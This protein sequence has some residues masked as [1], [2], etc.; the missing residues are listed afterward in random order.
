MMQTKV[1]ISILHSSENIVHACFEV[2]LWIK[3]WYL[4]WHAEYVGWLIMSNDGELIRSPTSV[5]TY[6]AVR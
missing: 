4:Y 2:F 1:N 5:V 3:C 6:G